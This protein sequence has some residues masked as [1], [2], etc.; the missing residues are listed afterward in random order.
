MFIHA[1]QRHQSFPFPSKLGNNA[2]VVDKVFDLGLLSDYE[3]ESF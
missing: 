2:F 1:V 3:K